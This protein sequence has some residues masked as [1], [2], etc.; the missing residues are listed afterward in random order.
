MRRLNNNDAKE[1]FCF[2]FFPYFYVVLSLN[3]IRVHSSPIKQ[4]YMHSF[5]SNKTTKMIFLKLREGFLADTPYLSYFSARFQVNSRSTHTILRSKITVILFIE[6]NTLDRKACFLSG[7]NLYRYE[8][9]KYQLMGAYF[10]SY[11]QKW[12]SSK[13]NKPI[14]SSLIQK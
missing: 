11:W 3:N 8:L 14:R 9:S 7:Q 1:F 5:E 12:Q 2:L 13:E 6:L 10:Y 4:S